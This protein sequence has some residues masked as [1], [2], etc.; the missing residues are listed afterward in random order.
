[1]PPATASAAAPC[2][3]P[4]PRNSPGMIVIG[5]DPAP[6]V[7]QIV[8]PLTIDVC[9]AH[10]IGDREEQ[11]DRVGMFPHALYKGAL[12]AVL[13]D[14]MGGL[15][16]GAMAAEQVIQAARQNFER[17]G[18]G[19]DAKEMLSAAI[20]DSHDSI[21]LTALSAEKD[22]HSTACVFVLTPGRAD[23]AHC[24]DSRIYQFRKGEMIARTVDH[25]LVMRKMVIPG[26]LT[27]EQAESHPN[28]N[29]LV[30]CLGE[31][32]RPE[33]DFGEAAP[34]QD[35]DCFLLCSDGIWAYFKNEELG[36]VLA[37]MT[38]REAA[39]ALLARARERA[40]GRGDNCSIAII[41]VKEVEAPKKP[42]MGKP[43]K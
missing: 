17:F 38:P 19:A 5:D 33:I 14:G 7:I 29:L 40:K 2:V 24:G 11:Q 12:L 10:H 4:S 32:A 28:K 23:W 27:E 9:K 20:N 25:S 31:E 1:M 43:R 26:Y 34:L 42:L 3:V 13:A 18:P 15:S 22:P 37:E 16:G 6:K 39:E 41:K 8:M 35:G 36:Q 30:S 21:K